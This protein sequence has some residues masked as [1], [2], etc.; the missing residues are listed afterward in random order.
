M[1]LWKSLLK[2]KEQRFTDFT[3]LLTTAN[4][5]TVV[6]SDHFIRVVLVF[7]LE[8]NPHIRD[9]VVLVLNDKIN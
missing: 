6:S 3:Q 5:E 4:A 7:I 1:N 2:Y 9:L 8:K